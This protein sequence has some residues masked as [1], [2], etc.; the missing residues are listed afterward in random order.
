M[1]PREE[2][3]EGSC[4]TT[5]A[6]RRRTKEGTFMT[7]AE[8]DDKNEHP[9]GSVLGTTA[10]EGLIRIDRAAAR[11]ERRIRLGRTLRWLVSTLCVSL[12]AA[13]V[14]LALRKTDHI[15][16]SSAR[17]AVVGEGVLV[18]VAAVIGYLRPL[19]MRAGAVA[20]DRHHGLADRLSSALSFGAMSDAERTP[21]MEA[22]IDDA[23][24]VVATV[25]PR[26][27]VPI[28]APRDLAL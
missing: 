1:C 22:A 24:A 8:V 18:L 10:R 6:A 25:S 14:T 9:S 13:A 19:P 28:R 23:V 2:L 21:F 17:I 15:A 11:A 16:E 20:L 7:E 3:S 4:V 27:A 5:D 12:V 26:K